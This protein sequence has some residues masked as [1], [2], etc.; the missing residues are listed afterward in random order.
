[1]ACCASSGVGPTVATGGGTMQKCASAPGNLSRPS[2]CGGGLQPCVRRVVG[3][4]T[5]R[6]GLPEGAARVLVQ[7]RGP[8]ASAKA[9]QPHCRAAG[10]WSRILRACSTRPCAG[11]VSARLQAAALQAEH[12][13]PPGQQPASPTPFSPAA[14]AWAA[15]RTAAPAPVVAPPPASPGPLRGHLLCSEGGSSPPAAA[16][17]CRRSRCSTAWHACAR[18]AWLLCEA[19]AWRS[20]LR[21][22]EPGGPSEACGCM[23]AAAG[24]I[25]PGRPVWLLDGAASKSDMAPASKAAPPRDRLKT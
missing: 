13:S 25:R 24:Q 3:M 4:Q 10:R 14:P 15:W 11:R 7:R 16:H 2:L 23:A 21:R 20:K 12:E 18:A 22:R 19:C 8:C 1:M 9:L 5:G 17:S 6:W